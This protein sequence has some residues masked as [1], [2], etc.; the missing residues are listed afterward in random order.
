MRRRVLVAAVCTICCGLATIGLEIARRDAIISLAVSVDVGR[1]LNLLIDAVPSA[2][3]SNK[4]WHEQYAEEARLTTRIQRIT[5]AEETS[6]ALWVACG[7][8]L[9]VLCLGQ[10]RG[11]A[12]RS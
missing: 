1:P 3:P 12:G 9:G 2:E 7:L 4:R 10:R 8:V 6:A 5:I 11:R